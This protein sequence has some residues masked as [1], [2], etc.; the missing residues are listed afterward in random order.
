MRIPIVQLR[1]LLI[2]LLSIGLGGCGNKSEPEPIMI[3]HVAPLS[4]A[5]KFRGEQAQQGIALAVEEA[6]AEGNRVLDRRVIVTH[7]DT[8]SDPGAVRS[9]VKRILSIDRVHA[10]LGGPETAALENVATVAQSAAVPFVLSASAPAAPMA[11]YIF[12]TGPTQQAQGRA[13]GQF[14]IRGIEGGTIRRRKRRQPRPVLAAFTHAV[15]KDSIV[16]TWTYAAAEKL[17]ALAKEVAAKKA[18][19]VLFVGKA[20]DFA[21]WARAEAVAQLPH[22]SQVTKES[23]PH[24]SGI[25]TGCRLCCVGVRSGRGFT[26]PQGVHE[27]VP[28]TLQP[29]DDSRAGA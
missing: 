8:R 12:F 22:S 9:V 13:L 20:S 19:G 18:T 14:C 26:C 2:G 25:V 28:R 16:G 1:L 29:P 3:G 6:S 10:I 23:L 7:A 11:D 24:C 4:A 21:E 15:P 17:P 5:D 27:Q